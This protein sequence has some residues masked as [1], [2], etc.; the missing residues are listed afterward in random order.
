M[1]YLFKFIN[2]FAAALPKEANLL[3][4]DEGWPSR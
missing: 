1:Y 2:A 3:L 4:A